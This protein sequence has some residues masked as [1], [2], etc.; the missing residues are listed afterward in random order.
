MQPLPSSNLDPIA[1]DLKINYLNQVQTQAYHSFLNSNQNAFLG[2][3]EGAGKF[4]LAILAMNQVLQNHKKV[5]LVVSHQ[6][7]AQKKSLLLSK[8]F[9]KKKVARTF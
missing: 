1:K 4:T 6:I 7:I 5:V 8:I 2:A 9:S 3:A